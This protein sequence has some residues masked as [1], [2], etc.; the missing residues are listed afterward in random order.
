MRKPGLIQ[1]TTVVALTGLSALL[2]PVQT[3]C[4]SF[5]PTYDEHNRIVGYHREFD[6]EKTLSLIGA[7]AIVAANA[8]GI[9]AAAR[10]NDAQKMM[11]IV[12]F[13]RTLASVAEKNKDKPV[14][15]AQFEG[16]PLGYRELGDRV[17]EAIEN[18]QIF[19]H[20]LGLDT[21]GEMPIEVKRLEQIVGKWEFTGKM[22]LTTGQTMKTKGTGRNRLIENGWFLR[23]GPLD[24]QQPR[25]GPNQF[26]L[27]TH[28]I[29]GWSP[30]DGMYHTLQ[31]MRRYA[32]GLEKPIVSFGEITRKYGPAS[33]VWIGKSEIITGDNFY[34]KGT[35][36]SIFQ[37]DTE[38][39]ESETNFGKAR[40]TARKISH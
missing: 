20:Y 26:Y 27:T 31:I 9:P 22:M 33:G 15:R 11:Q 38:S 29:T 28:S 40:A 30:K 12:Q 8:Y 19:A 39:Y 18:P 24:E 14:A 10:G 6:S 16:E 32:D 7:I 21:S 25:L 1:R 36:R 5:Q 13:S 2:M 35:S 17:N 3:G 23:G 4:T 34:S 37:G